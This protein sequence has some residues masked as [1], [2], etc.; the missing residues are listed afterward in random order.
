MKNIIGIIL[1]VALIIAAYFL[2]QGNTKEVKAQQ[3]F[4]NFSISDT[5]NVDQIFISDLKGEKILLTRRETG[6]WQ[7]E[8]KYPARRDAISLILKTL[9]DIEIQAPVSKSY[10]PSVVKRLATDG[11]KVQYFMGENKP[12]KTW[13]IGHATAAKIGTY[14]LLEQ[15]GEKSDKPYITH[16]LMERGNLRSR[17]FI[18]HTLWKERAMLKI[19][20]RKIKSIEVKH[21]ADSSTSFFIENLDVAT[22][23]ITNLKN[24]QIVS[25]DQQI[26]IP[27]FKLFAGIYYEYLDVNTPATQIDSVYSLIPRHQITVTNNSGKQFI[28]KTFNLPVRKGAEINGE[29]IFFNPEK[30]YAYSSELGKEE[31]PIVQNLTFNPLT[32]SFEFFTPSTT[33]EK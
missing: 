5:A 26:A 21:S 24:Q 8:G 27:Y 32:P 1:L 3:D 17:F 13:Y 23:Q 25:V 29:E 14:M 16:L 22:F 31:H 11:I 2:Y 15:D 9:H 12:S 4:K 28:L 20:P 30:M 7:V 19:N 33:V 6:K 18:N 10:Y